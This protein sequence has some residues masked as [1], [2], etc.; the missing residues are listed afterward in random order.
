[1]E[2]INQRL[3]DIVNLDVGLAYYAAQ[4]FGLRMFA[5]ENYNAN[6]DPVTMQLTYPA[7]AVVIAGTIASPTELSGT[8][9]CSAGPAFPVSYNPYNHDS[10]DRYRH[11]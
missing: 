6:T 2:R 7:V 9:A 11:S 10:L 5:V 3:A 8:S 1:M 4:N